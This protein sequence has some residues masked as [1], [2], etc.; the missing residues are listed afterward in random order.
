MKKIVI[1]AAITATLFAASASARSPW[2]PNTSCINGYHVV[3]TPWPRWVP[4]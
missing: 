3:Y 1:I 2:N 4:C